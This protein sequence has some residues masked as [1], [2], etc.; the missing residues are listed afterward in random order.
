MNPLVSDDGYAL[1]R[2]P[3]GVLGGRKVFRIRVQRK[4][5]LDY[6]SCI[7]IDNYREIGRENQASYT[8]TYSDFRDV[9]GVTF[10][11]HEDIKDEKGRSAVFEVQRIS[12][13]PGLVQAYFE[14][15]NL[16]EPSYFA[17]DRWLSPAGGSREVAR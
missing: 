4:D 12:P 6:V 10:A 1:D 5:G 17:V 13:N 15:S 3:D 2:L 9:A 14:M 8:T 7:D 16:T 11:F